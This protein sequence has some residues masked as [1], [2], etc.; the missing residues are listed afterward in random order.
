MAY[1]R[2]IGGIMKVRELVAKLLQQDQE[3]D[4][5]VDIK[6]NDFELCAYLVTGI[7]LGW[8]PSGVLSITTEDEPCMV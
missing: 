4:V 7:D 2:T 1:Q 6:L 5:V 8:Q 3:L